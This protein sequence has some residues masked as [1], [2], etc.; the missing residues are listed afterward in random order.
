MSSLATASSCKSNG[1]TIKLRDT[2]APA[3]LICVSSSD[4]APV[5]VMNAGPGGRR[6][7]G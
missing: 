5:V 7:L 4:L 6:V 3:R 2:T 1:L